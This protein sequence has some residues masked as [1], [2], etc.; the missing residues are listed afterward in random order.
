M[1]TSRNYTKE[2]SSSPHL[3]DTL[4]RRLQRPIQSPIANPLD[5][6][7]FLNQPTVEARDLIVVEGTTLATDGPV[8]FCRGE[9]DG[10]PAAVMQERSSEGLWQD[11]WSLPTESVDAREGMIGWLNTQSHRW[12]RFARM[13]HRRGSEELTHWIFELMVAPNTAQAIAPRFSPQAGRRAINQNSARSAPW[14]DNC[15]CRP[16]SVQNT[17]DF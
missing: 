4:F 17:R 16:G 3:G 14:I 8:R 11:I 12:D 2:T 15:S 1:S 10:R 13:F 6:P 9:V 5:I 7:H